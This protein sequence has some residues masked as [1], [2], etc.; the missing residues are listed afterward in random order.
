MTKFQEAFIQLFPVAGM[1]LLEAWVYRMHS[2][3]NQL[4]LCFILIKALE[5]SLGTHPVHGRHGV[6]LGGGD[7]GDHQVEHRQ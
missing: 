1:R 7:Q 2:P 5:E 6:L 4:L 3:F